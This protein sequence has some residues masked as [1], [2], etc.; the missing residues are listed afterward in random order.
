MIASMRTAGLLA[1]AL[2]LPT[3][4]H[5]AVVINEIAWMGT[6]A[7]ANAEWLELA[8]TDSSSVDLTGWHLTALS[9]SPAITLAGTIVGSGFFLFERT[10]D[11][12]VPDV[13]ADQI[14]TGAL[15][16][17]GTT[18][19]L[20]DAGG[21]AVDTVIG[22]AN[23]A[24][25]G[26][27]NANKQTAQRTADGWETAVATP[28][29]INAGVSLS[30]ESGTPDATTASSTAS[31]TAT[32]TIASGGGLAEYVPIPALRIVTT[33]DRS[34]SVGADVAFSASIYD[35]KGNKRSDAVVTWSFG[36]GMQRTG[37]SVF[38][39]FYEQGEYIVVTHAVT[40]DGGDAFSESVVTAIPASIEITSISPRGI[41][42]KNTSARTIDLSH[43]Q[44]SM[45]GQT[46]KMPADTQILAGRTVLFPVQVIQLPVAN[47]ASLL[48]PSGEVAATYP[49]QPR[50]VTVRYEEV[51]AVRLDEA[52]ARQV[53]TPVIRKAEPITSTKTNIQAYAEEVN[54][55]AAATELAVAGA[56][57]A[58]AAEADTR[59]WGLFRSPWTLGFLG[60][61]ALAGS[62]FI[63]L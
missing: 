19:T 50:P 61:V 32:G 48:Y 9:G 51:Q 16:N 6:T 1:L 7:S 42:V 13:T 62:A 49:A 35:G 17:I 39:P 15:T 18:L 8:N 5:A 58:A 2:F 47:S 23:W 36:D 28:R 34:V 53:E 44:L 31:T 22:G 59:D 24:N 26:G 4:A 10:S 43:W 20:I 41:S 38:H 37:A 21:V 14:Y 46:F 29:A 25:V 60:V 3:F 11:A 63:F 45:G 27:D 33:G 57:V 12:S 40:S 55:P 52:P 56:P 54:A 30:T